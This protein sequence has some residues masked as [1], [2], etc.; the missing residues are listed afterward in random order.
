MAFA[1]GE[2]LRASKLNR[3]QPTTYIGRSSADLNGAVTDTDITGATVT[4]TTVAANAV[5]VAVG[6]FDV[7]L[8]GATT[9]L[10]RG[11]LSVD[12][13]IQTPEAFLAAEVTTDRGTPGQIW[14]GTLGAAGNHTLKLVATLPASIS[15]RNPH[16]AIQVTIYE[17]I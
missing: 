13:A 1:S 11:K 17:V 8:T 14:R 10:A 12:G 7:D 6:I 3:V 2:R 4:V 5:Y 15:L 9:S 16:T